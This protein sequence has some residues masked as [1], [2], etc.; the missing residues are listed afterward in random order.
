MTQVGVNSE[1][2]I[3]LYVKYLRQIRPGCV[4]GI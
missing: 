3:L 1:I 2:F 4:I